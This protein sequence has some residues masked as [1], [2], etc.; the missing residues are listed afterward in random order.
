[1]QPQSALLELG[2]DDEAAPR[3]RAPIGGALD[4]SNETG[5]PTARTNQIVDAK[6]IHADRS[7]PPHAE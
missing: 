7:P 4:G 5:T 2:R 6:E 1:M 3:R